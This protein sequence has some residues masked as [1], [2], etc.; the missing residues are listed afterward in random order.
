MTKSSAVLFIHWELKDVLISSNGGFYTSSVVHWQSQRSA[1]ATFSYP[2]KKMFLSGLFGDLLLPAAGTFLT[3]V[4]TFWQ[5]NVLC[6]VLQQRQH[7]D[8]SLVS[9]SWREWDLPFQTIS[10]LLLFA[11]RLLKQ[12]C[13]QSFVFFRQLLAPGPLWRLLLCSHSLLPVSTM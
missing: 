9:S 4:L 8:W 12:V 7:L 3:A 6:R 10:L 11:S 2:F 13:P 5:R 1:D